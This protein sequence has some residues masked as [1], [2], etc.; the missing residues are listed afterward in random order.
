MNRIGPV[1]LFSLC[2]GVCWPGRLWA[3]DGTSVTTH[4]DGKNDNIFGGYGRIIRH[5]IR[6]D[7]VVNRV[8]LYDD[9]FLPARNP[10]FS[11]DGLRIGFLRRDGRVCVMSVDGGPVTVLSRALSHGEACLDWPQGNWIYYTRGGFSQP[12]GS[13]MLH[14]AD[15]T[16]GADEAVLTFSKDDGATECGTWRFG[17]AGNL[18][19]LVVRSNDFP[20]EPYG[21]VTAVDI[22]AEGGRL[23]LA[24]STDRWSCSAGIDPDGLVFMDGH[25]DHQGIDILDFGSLALLKSIRWEDALLWGPDTTE[26]G[27]S[28][29]RNSWSA[30]SDRWICV[31]IG[32]GIRGATGAN[33]MLVN[34]VDERRIV[35]TENTEG[36]YEFDCAGDFYVMDKAPSA[37]E[38]LEH[39]ENQTVTEGQIVS[40]AVTARGEP[41]V[42]YQWLRN[43]VELAGKS[44]PT[45]SLRASLEDDAAHFGCRVSNPRGS[46]LSEQALLT[47]QADSVAPTIDKVVAQG[48]PTVVRVLFSEP[49]AEAGA[50]DAAHYII[51]PPVVVDAV[52]LVGDGSE[53]LLA[54]G[55]LAMGVAYRLRVEKISDR[56]ATPNPLAEGTSVD[57]IYVELGDGLR[58]EYF[59]GQDLAGPAVIWYEPEIDYIWGSGSPD[60]AIAADFFSARWSGQILPP[61]TGIYS[62][63]VLSDDGVRIWLGGQMLIDAWKAQP[64]TEYR[65]DAP[66]TAGEKSDLRVEYFEAEGS[67]S[68]TLRWSGPGIQYQIVPRAALFSAGGLPANRAPR[69]EAGPEAWTTAGNDLLMEAEAT[70]DGRP[71]AL[72]FQWQTDAGPGPVVFADPAQATTYARFESPGDYLLRLVADDGD[73]RGYDRVSVHVLPPPEITLLQPKGG[74]SYPAGSILEINWTAYGVRDVRIDYSANGGENWETVEFSLDVTSPH[75]G[76]YPWRLPDQPTDSAIIQLSEYSLITSTRSEPFAIVIP[77]SEKGCSCQTDRR[78]AQALWL[79]LCVLLAGQVKRIRLTSLPI[80]PEKSVQERRKYD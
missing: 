28:H 54:T 34:W 16:T 11:P 19:Y 12:S 5:D 45:L 41:A 61:E 62:F 80:S 46:V 77:A 21:R 51:E 7:Q 15:A 76:R 72:S 58:A 79:M 59:D 53:A 44:E 71:D 68:I 20:P 40:F 1:L 32:W 43:D 65:A 4:W 52:S 6:A 33:Q 38:I 17:L 2:V 14:R 64:P 63:Y 67:A 73:K 57:F 3:V 50:L 60:P 9:P 18:R 35:V 78:S 8:V 49:V 29:D 42:L 70:D 26:T 37:P 74:E 23:P 25:Q 10:V 30:N 75:W 56:A 69:V 22:L 55:T 24:R 47:V 27:I 31:H 36:S 39:P 48:D 13:K 66:L